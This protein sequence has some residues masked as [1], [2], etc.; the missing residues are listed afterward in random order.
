MHLQ[1]SA[2]AFIVFTLLNLWTCLA[3]AQDHLYIKMLELAQKNNAEAQYHIGMFLNNGI[4]VPKDPKQAFRWFEKGARNGDM[5][6]EY[7][8]GCYLGGQFGDIVPLDDA[9][10]L[11]HKLK[12][13]NAGYSL[14]QYDVSIVYLKRNDV[15]NAIRWIQAAAAQGV[16]LALYNLSVSYKDGRGVP[17]DKVRTYSYFKLAKLSSEGNIPQKA[18]SALDDLKRDMSANEV[19]AAEQFVAHWKPEPTPLTLLAKSGLSR[20]KK[21]LEEM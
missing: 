14:A 12:A 2:R 21:M 11:E 3:L 17:V 19:E 4:G 15:D 18:Q 5:L 6:A 13:A 20:A 16:P 1:V 9:L 8:V 7:K 10:A